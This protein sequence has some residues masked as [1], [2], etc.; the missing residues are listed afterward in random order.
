MQN[1]ST[2]EIEEILTQYKPLV[3]KLAK[4]YYIQG[5]D[6]EDLIQEGMI[7]LYGSIFSYDETKSSF[8]TYA[9]ICISSRLKNVVKHSFS[10]NQRV[11]SEAGNIDDQRD[12]ASGFSIEDQYILQEEMML[13][14][15]KVQNLLSEKEFEILDMFLKNMSYDEIAEA[16]NTTKK[17]VDNALSRAKKKIAQQQIKN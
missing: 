10:K 8:Q 7:A 15:I 5:G 6:I 4:G 13:F 14:R 12:I 2:E 9:Y 16:C 3:L 11:L 1:Y 17:S